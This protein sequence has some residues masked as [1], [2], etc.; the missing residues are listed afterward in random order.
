LRKPQ[1]TPTLLSIVNLAEG[2]D[3]MS[4]TMRRG[5]ALTSDLSFGATFVRGIA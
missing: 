5:F 2:G 1:T 3:P 4:V